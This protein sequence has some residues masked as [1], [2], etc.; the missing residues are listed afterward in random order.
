MISEGIVHAIGNNGSA[1]TPPS[2]TITLSEASSEL[3]GNRPDDIRVEAD[4][5]GAF[6]Q[7]VEMKI[8]DSEEHSYGGNRQA[9]L[10]TPYGNQPGYDRYDPP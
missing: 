3:F 2:P 6:G 7:S 10:L 8:T 5:N 4:A 9:Y 1:G